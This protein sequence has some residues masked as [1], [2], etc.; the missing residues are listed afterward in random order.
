MYLILREISYY[1]IFFIRLLIFFGFKIIFF[2]TNLENN[3]FFLSLISQNKILHYSYFKTK[4][5]RRPH[6]SYQN[7]SY[8]LVKKCIKT[9]NNFIETLSKITNL[10]KKEIKIILNYK[11]RPSFI[12]NDYLKLKK[13]L[14]KEKYLDFFSLFPE[15]K[16]LINRDFIFLNLLNNYIQIL[17]TI[18]HKI[19]SLKLTFFQNQK[20]N[21]FKINNK[22]NYYKVA[23]FP[24]KTI[25]YGLMYLKDDFYIK[26]KNS[27]FNK[28]KILHLEIENNINFKNKYLSKKLNFAVINSKNIYLDYL[29]KN[30]NFLKILTLPNSF[31]FIKLVNSY[32][33]IK[34]FFENPNL[35]KLSY[36]IAANDY[37]FD[38][39]IS[40]V[41]KQKNIKII[42][43]QDR[44]VN[45]LYK[46][47]SAYF[48][49][50]LVYDNFSL[51]KYKKNHNM[52]IKEYVVF[53][54]YSLR[55]RINASKKVKI[56]YTNNKRPIAIF[57]I[58][59]SSISGQTLDVN[60]ENQLSF[61]EDILILCKKYPTENF[62][63]KS[64]NYDWMKCLYFKNFLKEVSKIKNLIIL[65]KSNQL[66]LG[67]KLLKDAK[68]II[69]KPSSVVDESLALKKK[70]IVHDFEKNIFSTLKNYLNFNQED[71]FSTSKKEFYDKFGKLMKSKITKKYK[72]IYYFYNFKENTKSD[73]I[74][75]FLLSLDNT[76]P[77]QSK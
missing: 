34:T 39:I 29:F 10:K 38:P 35:K 15:E 53:R 19:F 37:L 42:G 56:P 25:D 16:I 14:K 76:K 8:K 46:T 68:I 24:H 47:H 70:V 54:N 44:Y 51:S 32:F 26:N 27:I 43:K 4:K 49:Y 55:K 31:F 30:Y 45:C 23:Y 6:Q 77:K 58:S 2:K 20:K 1:N 60:F 71:I 40:L 5:H 28:S 50:L 74:Y 3:K 11:L 18:I 67:Y 75:N 17:K 62:Y 9:L 64:K 7:T 22:L 21:K 57:D 73:P 65:N 48:D 66:Y 72:N 33:S 69:T 41:L 52:T 63:L 36:V 59:C 61:Y 12:F 13:M